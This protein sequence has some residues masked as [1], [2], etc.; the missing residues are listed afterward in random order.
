MSVKFIKNDGILAFDDYMWRSGKGPASDPYP[1]I[2][3]ILTAFS[4]E[5][6]VIDI[7]L[8]VWLKRKK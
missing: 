6:E 3:A 8:Q 4:N 1:A 7:G 5:F 2:D